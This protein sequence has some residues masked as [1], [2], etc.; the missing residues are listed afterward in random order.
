MATPARQ[1][2]WDDSTPR[3]RSSA[4]AAS[5]RVDL[6]ASVSSAQG[7][8][9]FAPGDEV[10]VEDVQANELPA[11][12]TNTEDVS[13]RIEEA[14]GGDSKLS[15]HGVMPTSTKRQVEANGGDS[16][17]SSHGVMP[18][19]TKRQVEAKH[20]LV[21]KVEAVD[22]KVYQQGEDSEII[23]NGCR[24]KF[25]AYLIY[26]E[27]FLEEKNVPP[28][29]PPAP[30]LETQGS[31]LKRHLEDSKGCRRVG[32][33]GLKIFMFLRKI[34]LIA[35]ICFT[36]C[37]FFLRAFPPF[38]LLPS[39]G[40][41]RGFVDEYPWAIGVYSCQDDTQ[42]NGMDAEMLL[43]LASFRIESQSHGRY[44]VVHWGDE[45]CPTELASLGA[46]EYCVKCKEA[47]FHCA[48]LSITSIPFVMVNFFLDFQRLSERTDRNCAKTASLICNF[49]GMML[50][51]SAICAFMNECISPF[52]RVDDAGIFQL[53]LSIGRG[54]YLV[55]CSIVIN[56]FVLVVHLTLPSPPRA[57]DE[58]FNFE[59]D[60]MSQSD[61]VKKRAA[62]R[63][64]HIFG[65]K[66][67]PKKAAEKARMQ[68]LVQGSVTPDNDMDEESV[69]SEDEAED[70]QHTRRGL[71]SVPSD[72]SSI[73]NDRQTRTAMGQAGSL[74]SDG[75][76]P[77]HNRAIGRESTDEAAGSD[78][79]AKPNF[80]KV[81]AM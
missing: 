73:Q 61:S 37:A 52:P 2:A 53:E 10:L 58:N 46:A 4:S 19:S 49:C 48:G 13:R 70:D 45:D 60:R 25:I 40:K 66:Y 69:G 16:K 1:S 8:V 76:A 9:S 35:C 28:G 71:G 30:C 34:T 79:R 51:I 18:T 41:Y 67:D 57:W 11:G 39:S 20:S 59:E 47:S 78:T 43:G 74:S 14:N 44:K 24:Q 31:S 7:R 62:S 72:A 63:F 80:L 36:T 17:L 65:E 75:S 12:S 26:T 15:L 3:P 23:A 22:R 29:L 6:D 21:S 27:E 50:L 68:A 32:K 77:A 33:T 55:V 5:R 54:G 42:C 56:L 64:V 38:A 81:N